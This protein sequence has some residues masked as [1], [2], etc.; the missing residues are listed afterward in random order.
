MQIERHRQWL[1][2]KGLAHRIVAGQ[3]F[4]RRQMWITPLGPAANPFQLQATEAQSLVSELGGWWVAWTTPKDPGAS[5]ER[6]YAVVCKQFAPVDA[7]PAKRR[8]EMNRALRNCEV[9]RVA[10][11]EIGRDGYETYVEALRGYAGGGDV[12]VPTQAE[13]AAGLRRESEFS[14]IRHH[15]GV[16]HQGAMVGYAHCSIYGDV[17]ADYSYVKL[18]PKFLSL[19]PG[20]ALIYRMNEFYLG[21]EKF[22]YVNDGWRSVLHDTGMQKFLIQKFGF[23]L[24]PLDLNL[25]FR[26]PLGTM[27]NLSVPVHPLLR[28]ANRKMAALLQLWSLRAA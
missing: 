9:R 1:E 12:T 24:M 6:W 17:E 22:R 10:A 7:L 11:E 18:H 4:F 21:T 16:Y 14:D 15:W 25:H 2:A 3:L 5:A 28:R 20:Y 8:S 26:R 27:L 23:E 13:F 19:Y